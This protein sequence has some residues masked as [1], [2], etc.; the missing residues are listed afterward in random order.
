[1]MFLAN[2][3]SKMKPV[4]AKS[5]LGSRIAEVHNGSSLFTGDAGQ[6]ESNT[7]RWMIENDWLEAI[8][9]LPLN[10]FYNTGIA[11]YV[12]VLTNRKA[13]HRKGKVQLI[14]ATQWFK[15]LRKNMGKKN[16]ELSAEDIKRMREILHTYERV[17]PIIAKI[18]NRAG[19]ANLE[20]IVEAADGIMV[21]RGDLG[22]ELPLAEVPGF[23]K[24]IIRTTVSAG[25]PTITA[26][27]MLASM[28]RNPK[29][30]RAEASDVANAILDGSS[31]VMLSGE[32]AMGKYPVQAVETMSTLAIRA[33]AAL[34]EYGFLQKIKP[35]AS[36]RVTEAVA[37]SS[38]NMAHK[39]GSSAI[40]SMTDTGFTSR[41]ISKHRPECPIVAIVRSRP[42][43]R[44]LAMN[45]GV[46]PILYIGEGNDEAKLEFAL[47]EARRLGLVAGGDTVVVTS[48][49]QQTTGGTDLIRII[50]ID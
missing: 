39:L 5:P 38:V 26:T 30:T 3:L 27:E 45:W 16:C 12:W 32:T 48:G 36:S 50:T 37:Q 35:N 4:T 29:P 40:F 46:T 47:K 34:S 43:A 28:E 44:R 24:K 9:A 20:H 25:K 13:E 31:A 49:Y 19:L 8:V 18:E 33:E 6:G 21:A 23:Q 22:V 10:M 7:R 15:P 14:D 42:V 1:M 2:M 41:L 11:T 17:I